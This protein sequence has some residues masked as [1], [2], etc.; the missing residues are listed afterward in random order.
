VADAVAPGKRK[1]DGPNEGKFSL[2]VNDLIK[3]EDEG[4]KEV[5]MMKKSFEH[6]LMALRF[7]SE[8]AAKNDL[9]AALAIYSEARTMFRAL[10]NLR[11]EGIATFNLAVIYHKIWL[12]SDKMDMHAFA[13]AKQYYVESVD[14]GNK[15]WNSLLRGDNDGNAVVPINPDGIEMTA[16]DGAGQKAAVATLI[17]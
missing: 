15:I 5:S 11:G 4:C 6:M 3:P 13:N 14:N 12:Q 2:H 9:K 8:S 16:V 17:C 7:G 1:I 10:S